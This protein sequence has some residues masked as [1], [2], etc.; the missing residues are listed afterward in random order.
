M[1]SSQDKICLYVKEEYKAENGKE[2]PYFLDY[3][4]GFELNPV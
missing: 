3:S 2:T 1:F 4:P